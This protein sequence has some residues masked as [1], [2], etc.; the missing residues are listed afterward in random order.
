MALQVQV[1]TDLHQNVGLYDFRP[2]FYIFFVYLVGKIL[3]SIYIQANRPTIS[4]SFLI[5]NLILESFNI[6]T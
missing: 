1:L 3:K 4:T 6:Q 5:T 2:K